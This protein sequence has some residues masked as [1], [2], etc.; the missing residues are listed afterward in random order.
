MG[1]LEEKLIKGAWTLFSEINTEACYNSSTG[2][3]QFKLSPDNLLHIQ[4]TL[5]VCEDKIKDRWKGYLESLNDINT[6][7]TRDSI[8]KA[9][10]D[11]YSYRLYDPDGEYDAKTY[12]VINFFRQHESNHLKQ[13]ITDVNK[14]FIKYDYKNKYLSYSPLCTSEQYNVVINKADTNMYKLT[15]DF[16]IQLRKILLN[17]FS[18]SFVNEKGNPVPFYEQ[19][20]QTDAFNSDI[21]P[22]IKAL[23]ARAKKLKITC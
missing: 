18:K 19:K 1:I 10:Q 12:T 17:N 13:F 21:R 3:W 6:K 11:L 8:C 16:R 4:Y 14:Y 9:I 7:I 22:Y 5:V 2:K 23:D 15:R 20:A